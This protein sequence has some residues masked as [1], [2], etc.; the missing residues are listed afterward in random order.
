MNSEQLIATDQDIFSHR[1][2]GRH[3]NVFVL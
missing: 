1:L 2:L 3:G